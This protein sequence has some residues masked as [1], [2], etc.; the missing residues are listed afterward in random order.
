MVERLPLWPVAL[1]VVARLV[2]GL[3]RAWLAVRPSRSAAVHLGA[4]APAEAVGLGSLVSPSGSPLLVAAASWRPLAVS[5][6]RSAP[7][8]MLLAS[9][10]LTQRKYGT[11]AAMIVYLYEL[12]S[13]ETGLQIYVGI[14]ADPDERLKTHLRFSNAL[15]KP[16]TMNMLNMFFSYKDALRAESELH[17]DGANGVCRLRPPPWY[18]IPACANMTWNELNLVS[19]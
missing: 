6:R 5:S 12:V 8:L 4:P 10:S 16:Y 17:R 15:V 9:T 11:I 3:R 7:R 14:T 18:E 19:S 1:A 13:D 2:Y